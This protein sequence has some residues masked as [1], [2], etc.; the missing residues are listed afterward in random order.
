MQLAPFAD[1]ESR[2]NGAVERHL[3]NAVAVYEGGE[4][5]GVH[6]AREPASFERM[7]EASASP[8]AAFDIAH[9]PGLAI[10]KRLEVGGLLYVVVGGVVPDASGWVTVQL[11]KA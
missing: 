4:P 11:D 5:F 9:T 1:R 3:S 2:V 6:F 8:T 7:V 10:D